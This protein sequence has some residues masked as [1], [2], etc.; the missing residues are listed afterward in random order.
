MAEKALW[1]IGAAVAIGIMTVVFAHTGTTAKNAVTHT[2]TA[3]TK[4]V[5][6]IFGTP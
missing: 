1:M 4:S 6:K 2:G 5:D 3:V